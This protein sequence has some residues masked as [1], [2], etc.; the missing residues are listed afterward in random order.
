[1]DNRQKI[2]WGD[3]SGGVHTSRGGWRLIAGVVV[4]LVALVV[5][6]RVQGRNLGGDEAGPAGT[7]RVTAGLADSTAASGLVVAG[8]VALPGQAAAVVVGEGA[9]WVLLEQ[10]TLLR[11]DPDR[12]QVTGRLEL[13]APTGPLAVGAGAVWVGNGQATV[14]ARV[15]PVRLQV[16][17]RF[18]GYVVAVAHGVLWSYCCRRGY[19]PM[20]FSRVDAR[21]LRS[22]PPLVVTDAA[23][24]HQPVGRLAVGA[25]AVWTQTP[26]DERLW[27]VPLGRGP[28]RGVRV[29]G[30]GYGLVADA[31]AV[32][33]LS[34]TDP[35]GSERD[36]TGRLRRLD[37]RTGTVTATTPLPDL[38]VGLAA[39]PVLGGGA[40]WLAGPYTRLQD[41]GGI[42]LRVDPASG[43]VTGWL[44]SP[45]GFAQDVLAA[46][47]HG[48]WV[49]TAV[50]ELLHLVPA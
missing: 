33:V 2:A 23:G 41:G 27:R 10:G 46:G 25:D 1:V 47:P 50:P 48:A 11:V 45:L 6:G 31:G 36:R 20:G 12:Q 17:A 42:L 34:G 16:T 3:R 4:M 15:D 19:K 9:V 24:R 18:G 32:W 14:T 44:R 5:V 21:T 38:A 28:A 22:R 8:R 40:V 26:E 35:P 29:P 43:R 13:G 49:G 7:A 39:G 37:Q 30:T